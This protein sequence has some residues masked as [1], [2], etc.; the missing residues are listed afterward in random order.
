MRADWR[1]LDAIR[2]RGYKTPDRHVGLIRKMREGLR[3]RRVTGVAG[4][5]RLIAAG[6]AVPVQCHVQT[7]AADSGD[8]Q[9][10]YRRIETFRHS[11][12][13][14]LRRNTLAPLAMDAQ[15]ES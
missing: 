1:Q 11:R 10:G 4:L 2:F 3:H 12:R 13:I 5:A 15:H 7:E 6:F 8:Q 9:N 14:I